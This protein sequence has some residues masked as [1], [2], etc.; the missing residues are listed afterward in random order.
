M[1]TCVWVCAYMSESVWGPEEVTEFL[2][3]NYEQL[4]AI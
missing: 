3:W 2:V 4:S 1:C